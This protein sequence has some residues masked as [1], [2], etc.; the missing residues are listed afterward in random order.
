MYV[1]EQVRASSSRIGNQ[2]TELLN[3]SPLP[4]QVTKSLVSQ[5]SSGFKSGLKRKLIQVTTE[6]V[7]CVAESMAPGQGME[8]LS[9]LTQ[10]SSDDEED[11]PADILPLLDAYENSDS[12]GRHIILSLVDVRHTKETIQRCFGCTK[13]AVDHARKMKVSTEGITLPSNQKFK[14]NRMNKDKCEDFLSFLF[15]SGILQDV[16]YGVTNLVFDDG[17]KQTVP[18]AVLTTRFS[19]AISFYKEICSESNF[20][21]LSDSSLWRILRAIKPSQ[22]KSLSGLDDITA[23]GMNGFSYLSDY[24]TSLKRYKEL[25]DQLECGKRYLKMRYQSHC[26]LDS[27]IASHNPLF[28]LSTPEEQCCPDITD[29]VCVDCNNLMSALYK[30]QQ[31]AAAESSEDVQYDINKSIDAIIKYMQHQMRDSQQRRAKSFC[32]DNLDDVT[33]FWLKDFAQKVLPQRY[34]EGQKEYF[35]KKGMSLH[36]DVFFRKENDDL[37]KYVYFSCIFRS[38]QTMLDVLNIGD[39]VLQQFRSDCPNITR[40]YAKSDNAGSYHGNF[41]LEA[42]YKLC[43]NYNFDLLR[44]DY[45]E[46]CKGKDQCDRESAGAKNVINSFVN[47]GNTMKDAVGLFDALHYGKGIK[48]SKVAVLEINH[49]VS[50]LKGEEIKNISSFHSA[51][52]YT[53]HMKLYRYFRI[54]QGRVVKYNNNSKFTP[55]YLKVRNF[56]QTQKTIVSS[57]SNKKKKKRSDHEVCRLIFCA[58]PSCSKTFESTEEYDRHMLSEQHEIKKPRSSLDNVRASFVQQI[59]ASSQL[60]TGSISTEVEL[61]DLTLPEVLAENPL[62]QR[63]TNQGWALPIRLFFRY[64]YKQKKM[65][66]DIFMAGERTGKKKSPDEVELILR[67]E[68]QPKEYVTPS[69]IRTLFS[70]FA[71]KLKD[72]TL[73][74]PKEKAPK[75]KQSKKKENKAST[76]SAEGEVEDDDDEVLEEVV[77]RDET[78]FHEEVEKSAFEVMATLA[79]WEVGE[80]VAL[81]C[82]DS[83]YPGIVTMV[84]D[85]G[86]A[87]VKR[88]KYTDDFRNTN[89]F[90][91]PKKNDERPYGI[92]KLLLKLEPPQELRST[93]RLK[94]YE[95]SNKDFSCACDLLVMY[96][97][98]H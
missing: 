36:I 25:L 88:M 78:D 58:E 10:E 96:L 51:E 1:P 84:N 37:L 9:E 95:F 53:D 39:S 68:L 34:R 56:S 77:Q 49:D 73:E 97:R 15:S 63:I 62:M 90:A 69:Q 67:S 41:I 64:S 42:T 70:S 22:R 45:N 92:D 76:S 20:I 47:A 43:K 30:I 83:W 89:K 19:H 23:D 16:A 38:P 8:L 71:T 59:K 93:K 11:I 87:K 54:G 60:H 13:Y 32:F 52:F 81:V 21:P 44:Y 61:A 86:T 94:L 27:T 12:Q 31:I 35:G 57:V 72:G 66:Y 26:S 33:A 40:L 65:L 46:P 3:V 28:A 18:H 79:E 14:R 4:N 82:N 48:N 80:Y 5:L 75:R 17:T 85:D 24:I 55:S 98:K 7:K 50:E 91:W 2:L 29:E 74:E 6:A